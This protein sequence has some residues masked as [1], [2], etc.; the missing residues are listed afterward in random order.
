MAAHLL[1][2]QEAGGSNPPAPT[3]KPGG[4]LRDPQSLCRT[5]QDLP[6]VRLERPWDEQFDGAGWIWSLGAFVEFYGDAFGLEE[7]LRNLAL[8]RRLRPEHRDELVASGHVSSEIHSR[9]RGRCSP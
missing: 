3:G 2:E 9:S 6:S 5:A 1:W 8:E 7:T 4:P